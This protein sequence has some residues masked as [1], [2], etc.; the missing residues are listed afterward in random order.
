MTISVTTL[1]IFA[2][3][4]LGLLLFVFLM[5]LLTPKI[6]GLINKKKYSPAAD[7]AGRADEKNKMDNKDGED[8]AKRADVF[9]PSYNNKEKNNGK[10]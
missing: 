8:I 7:E 5:A 9:G 6:A 4:A 2:V 3:K 10:E 1:I